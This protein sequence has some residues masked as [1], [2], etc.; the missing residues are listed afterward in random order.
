MRP[1]IEDN[2]S[3]CVSTVRRPYCIQRFINSVRA[4]FASIPII[5]GDQNGPNRYL[6]ACYENAGVK[7]VYVTEDAGV[8]IARHA[9]IAEVKTEYILFCDDDFIFSKE[10]KLEAPV[11]ILKHDP[12]ID[13]VGGVVKDL[14]SR[15]DDPDS[16]NY[17]MGVI[18]GVQQEATPFDANEY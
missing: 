11:E 13:I 14:I 3:I 5:V 4:N 6:Q 8:G 12:D 2:I 17:P 15:I 10:T 1:S 9:A 7:A 18:L 16:Q